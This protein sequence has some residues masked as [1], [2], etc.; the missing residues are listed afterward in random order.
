MA[1]SL[2]LIFTMLVQAFFLSQ[3]AFADAK[4]DC[5][6]ESERSADGSVN[7]VYVKNTNT[8]KK[9]RATVAVS[10]NSSRGVRRLPDKVILLNAGERVS[11]GSDRSGDATYTFTISGA[12][13]E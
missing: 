9:V 12:S 5:R 2:F 1:K 3:Q 4:S 7:F 8:N 11:L 6:I 10:E 13:Y